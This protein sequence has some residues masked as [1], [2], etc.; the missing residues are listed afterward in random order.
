[1]NE[2]QKCSRT[3]L[4]FDSGFPGD[5]VTRVTCK[6]KFRVQCPRTIS[7][8]TRRKERNCTSHALSRTNRSPSWLIV[9]NL[10]ATNACA[11]LHSQ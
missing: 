11:V 4:A 3:R 9:K 7:L 5:T 6:S 2:W 10:S 8:S 1:M